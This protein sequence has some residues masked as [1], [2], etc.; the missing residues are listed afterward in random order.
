MFIYLLC[1]YV[2]LF[3]H[4]YYL[5]PYVNFNIKNLFLT[6]GPLHNSRFE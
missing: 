6:L 4:S 2:K 5:I 1:N 3:S